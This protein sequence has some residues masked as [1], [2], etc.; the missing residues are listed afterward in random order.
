MVQAETIG[1]YV[2]VMVLVCA[3]AKRRP[4]KGLLFLSLFVPAYLVGL[5]PHVAALTV[6]WEGGWIPGN[7]G[8]AAGAAAWATFGWLVTGWIRRN[9]RIPASA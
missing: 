2:I 6:G 5:F 7:A 9:P 1:T 8:A 4:F 3:L